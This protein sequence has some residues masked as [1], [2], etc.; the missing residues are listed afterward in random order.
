MCLPKIFGDVHSDQIISDLIYENIVQ[1]QGKEQTIANNFIQII[2]A[3]SIPI[4]NKLN[5]K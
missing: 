2:N 3:E 4:T 1:I 5:R